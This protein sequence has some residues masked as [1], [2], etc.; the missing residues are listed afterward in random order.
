MRVTELEAAIRADPDDVA[1][2]QVYADALLEV[3]DPRGDHLVLAAR[4]PASWELWELER[5]L[6]ERLVAP[7]A[8]HHLVRLRWRDGFVDEISLHRRS[9]KLD[10]QMYERLHEVLEQPECAA[11]RTID[12]RGSWTTRIAWY[13]RV[14][15]LVDET[16]SLRCIGIGPGDIDARNVRNLL[17]TRTQLDGVRLELR[18][19]MVEGVVVELARH[20]RLRAV[21]VHAYGM[22]ATRIFEHLAGLD[23]ERLVVRE[24]WDDPLDEAVVAQ[25]LD[26]RV[27][28]RLR[29]LG[30]M[31]GLDETLALCRALVDSPLLRRLRAFGLRPAELYDDAGAQGWF[32]ARA[33][34]FAHCALFTE[35]DYHEA[36]RLGLLLLRLGRG[37]EAIAELSHHVDATGTSVEHAT[38]WAELG[39]CYL[40]AGRADLAL[41][42]IDRALEFVDATAND[43][44]QIHRTHATALGAL[45]RHDEAIAAC[46]RALAIDNDPPTWHEYERALRALGRH[47]DAALAS[48]M[49]YLLEHVDLT[50]PEVARREEGKRRLL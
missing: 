10:P 40:D 45:G 46:R 24:G 1:L 30:F 29:E 48:E 11:V 20:E 19:D 41:A 27:W 17:E 44:V 26:G 9:G 39:E 13:P 25:I 31:A 15:E 49:P 8:E 34:Q 7:L 12:L 6:T 18:S 4:D 3:G 38:C 16:P 35:N 22:S 23:L 28:P 21:E 36:G 33:E 47:D 2:R 14:A 42:P 37:R 43:R 32:L 5:D 50:E